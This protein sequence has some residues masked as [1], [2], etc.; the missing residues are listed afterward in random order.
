VDEAQKY[1]LVAGFAKNV[2]QNAALGIKVVLIARAEAVFE[3]P[4]AD[5]LIGNPDTGVIHGGVITTLLDGI[6]GCAVLAGLDKLEPLATLDL[7]ID[8]LKPATPNRSVFAK[9]TCYHI[10]KNVAFTRAVAYHDDESDAI[11][12]S[13]GTFMLGTNG[14]SKS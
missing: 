10:T 1:A 14:A 7:R 5:H 12:H 6:S 3:L 2:P 9:A 13:V 11:A 4:Y 8:Y